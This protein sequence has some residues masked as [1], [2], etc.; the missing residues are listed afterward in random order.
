MSIAQ[1]FVVNFILPAIQI[2]LF[3]I[4]AR[5][6]MSWLVALNIIN[7]RNAFVA[8]LYEAIYKL[9]EPVMAPLR[10]IIPAVGGL[11]LSPICLL[12]TSPSPRDRG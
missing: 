11:D 6:I 10:R 1:L 9:T 5:I 12:Y 3:I 8:Q 7:F 2:Y 4:I